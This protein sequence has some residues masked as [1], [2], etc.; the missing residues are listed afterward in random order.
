HHPNEE[1][2][3]LITREFS[4]FRDDPFSFLRNV[5]LHYTGSG[6]RAYEKPIGQPIFYKGFTENM[7]GNVLRAEA[8]GRKIDELAERRVKKE[9]EMGLLRGEGDGELG[10]RDVEKVER[11]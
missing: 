8:L 4:H 10:G 6:W 3:D 7:K 1:S 9:R 5:S 11:R 2:R